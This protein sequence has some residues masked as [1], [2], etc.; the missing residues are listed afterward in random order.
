MLQYPLIKICGI[1]NILDALHAVN[2][3]ATAIGFNFYSK[4]KRYISP[5]NAR[6]IADKIRNRITI[7]GLFVNEQISVV[8]EIQNTVGLHYLQFHGDETPKYVSRF[9]SAI[10]VF[11]VNNN[12]ED[13]LI[14]QYS[15]DAILFD[16]FSEG[17]FGG[18]GRTFNWK[19]TEPF[20]KKY[21]VIIAGGLNPENVQGAIRN[22][23]PFGVDVSSGVEIKPGV[24]DK[25]K[26][27]SFINEAR[28]AF[29]TI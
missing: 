21:S 11:R 10:K 3:G 23:K 20:S 2:A 25:I 15:T 17:E 22:A 5:N 14:S 29:E 26:V 28:T 9:S 19:L 27:T 6:D 16:T 13:E 4:S 24:K 7:I 1:T 18:T 8:Q 12:I